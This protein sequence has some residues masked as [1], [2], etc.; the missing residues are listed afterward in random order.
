MIWNKIE[1]TLPK[2]MNEVL[3]TDGHGSFAVAVCYGMSVYHGQPIWEPA[4]GL[5][6]VDDYIVS[7]EIKM[8]HPVTEW[9]E[10]EHYKK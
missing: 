2:H 9:A 3:V 6:E 7:I 5:L 1:D 8:D 10:I 4:R